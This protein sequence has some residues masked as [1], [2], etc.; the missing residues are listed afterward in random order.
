[1]IQ[2]N[3]RR[4][5]KKVGKK[6]NKRSFSL[7]RLCAFLVVFL[8]LVVSVC[9]VGYVIFF[10][11]VFAQE[12]LPALKSAIVFEE[13]NPPVHADQVV[14]PVGPVKSVIPA[15]PVEKEVIARTPEAR[16]VL[17]KVAIIMDDMGYDETVGEQL[18]QFPVELTYSFLPFAPYTR[19]LENLA[20]LAGKTVFLH[21]PLEPK[22]TT[23]SPGP[24]ALFLHDSPEMQLDKLAKCLQEV[25]H[26]VGVN[27][28][29]GSYFT[30]DKS[31]MT[32][33]IHEMK[34][35][36]LM[37]VDSFTT[38]GSVALQVAKAASVKSAGRS[39]FLDN[40]LDEGSICYQLEKLV[41]IAERRGWAI[42][43]AHPH[44]VT[45]SAI[46]VCNGKYRGRVEYV[47]VSEVLL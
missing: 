13:P 1:M 11:T 22:G 17:P 3:K 10:R 36:S 7:T 18:L 26:A 47:G 27:N 42:G 19:K 35:R 39:V 15:E 45:V 38:P 44:R 8:L 23:Y 29:M 41:V 43:I 32:T 28:H 30:E 6:K 2:Q 37:F 31:A 5:R 40:T 25:P 14:E 21:L 34:E 24:G 33:L 9:A 20:F 4:L 12:I 16:P 46:E